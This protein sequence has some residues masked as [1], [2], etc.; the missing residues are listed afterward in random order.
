M[1]RPGERSVRPRSDP[2]VDIATVQPCPTPPSTCA[3]GTNTSS[4]NT[5]A[6]PGSPSSCAIPRTVTPS[7]SRGTRK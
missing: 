4:R 1:N 2:V 3:S 6:K 7:A 5:S